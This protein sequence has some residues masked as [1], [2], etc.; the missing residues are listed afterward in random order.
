VTELSLGCEPSVL[1]SMTK[2]SANLKEIPK[3]K[4]LFLDIQNTH[5]KYCLFKKQDIIFLCLVMM[6][7][8]T[9][10]QI[11]IIKHILALGKPQGDCTSLLLVLQSD[12]KSYPTIF[13]RITLICGMSK[14][15]NQMFS[16]GF[17]KH[18]R[19]L[20]KL[21]AFLASNYKITK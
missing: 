4:S 19:C 6:N 3:E 11:C 13:H 10:Y 20:E 12:F 21:E 9:V 5:V 15:D 17:S 18:C 14:L 8:N 16:P 7:F 1:L 2:E